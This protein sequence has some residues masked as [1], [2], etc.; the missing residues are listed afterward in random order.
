M[1]G[2]GPDLNQKFCMYQYEAGTRTREPF[3][4]I[5]DCEPPIYD[6]CSASELE[7][8]GCSLEFGETPIPL[9][10]RGFQ[11]VLSDKVG[12]V[13]IHQTCPELPQRLV[14]ILKGVEVIT[15]GV[16]TVDSNRR[17]DLIDE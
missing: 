17:L 16:T 4:A 7:R 9:T 2:D 10:I 1:V 13:Q 5:D 3:C 12:F 6:P 14:N 8:C 15:S 11:L